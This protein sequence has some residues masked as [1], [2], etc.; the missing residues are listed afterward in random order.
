[1]SAAFLLLAAL[2]F[3]SGLWA[4]ESNDQA[5]SFSS[6]SIVNSGN[7]SPGS[8]SPNTIASVYG[9]KL[10]FDTATAPADLGAASLPNKLAGVQVVVGGLLASLYHVS[11]TQINFVIPANLLPGRVSITVTRQATSATAQVTLL[12]AA[13]A[14][15]VTADGSLAATHADGSL[16]SAES[17]ALPGEII[18][19]YGTGLGRT[20]PRQ[21]DGVIPRA[22]AFIMPLDR[23]QIFLDG[24]L[25]PGSSVYYAGITPGFPGLYQ[26]NLRIPEKISKAEQELR[27]AMSDQTSQTALLLRFAPNDGEA[28]P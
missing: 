24:E 16:I 23:L 7:G 9:E 2:L 4:Q 10:S 28:A 18:V 11:P 26:I 25:L 8:L 21:Q 27:V 15:F 1:V 17:P 13:P 22:A 5:P 12:D 3:R 6:D 19:I 14:L 20:D